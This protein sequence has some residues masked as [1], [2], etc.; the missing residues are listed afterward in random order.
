MTRRLRL[1][2]V[3]DSLV[4]RDRDFCAS[5]EEWSCDDQADE[6]QQQP[7]QSATHS[8]KKSLA[9]HYKK[10]SVLKRG[11]QGVVYLAS[12]RKKHKDGDSANSTNRSA[13]VAIKRMFNDVREERMRGV[14]EGI[15]REIGIL[16]SIAAAACSSGEF[17]KNNHN[18]I[19]FKDVVFASGCT[20]DSQH[21]SSAS[22]PEICLVME[23]CDG[24]VGSLISNKSFNGNQQQESFVP[25]DLII[26]IIQGTLKAL[27]FLH[28]EGKSSNSDGNGSSSSTTI[29]LHR[30]VKPSNLLIRKDVEG[31]IALA[32]FGSARLVFPTSNNNNNIFTSSSSTLSNAHVDVDVDVNDDG[33]FGRKLPSPQQQQHL[34]S[35]A[36]R[37]TTLPYR[38]PEI[39]L[40][41]RDYTSA[42][43]IWGLGVVFVELLKGT[44]LF[45][46]KS[47]MQMLS[48][49]F[50]LVGYP[51]ETTWPESSQFAL[52]QAF[53]FAF[54]QK[55][56]QQH[57]AQDTNDNNSN[58]HNSSSGTE[59]SPL[60]AHLQHWIETRRPRQER[61]TY[62]PE[63]ETRLIDLIDRMLSLNPKRRPSAS[64]CL[65]DPLFALV[66]PSIEGWRR[67]KNSRRYGGGGG[68]ERGGETD[69]QTQVTSSHH[70]SN[71]FGIPPPNLRFG[72]G[73][74]S[75]IP[76]NALLSLGDD[77][78]DDGE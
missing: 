20:G 12:A 23:A 69:F 29:I 66:K 63:V 77:D 73:R 6:R 16:K 61:Q 74:E 21:S 13:I 4:N 57:N 7:D 62:G 30:D 36:A 22:R 52:L 40:G 8:T 28:H 9:L 32:D 53:S 55:G 78:D 37:R 48:Q 49:L 41:Q 65:A 10:I 39:L 59:P 24:D 44:H 19:R 45:N 15:L 14:P 72:S 1:G 76:M 58:N 50:S 17:D 38:A 3:D 71:V 60:R 31:S 68:G 70:S 5:E 35:P 54:Q 18:I 64:D 51:N 56:Q 11:S 47:E 75:G 46:A 42:I 2:E 26:H 43:D 33:K 27:Q 25:L 34:H 67:I